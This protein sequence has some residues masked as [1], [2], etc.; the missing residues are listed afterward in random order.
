[1]GVF[2]CCV[3]V[4]IYSREMKQKAQKNKGKEKELEALDTFFVLFPYEMGDIN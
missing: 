4:F 1:M 2:V 3:R